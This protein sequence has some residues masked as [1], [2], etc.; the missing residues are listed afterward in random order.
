[1][2]RTIQPCAA[3]GA[4]FRPARE[5]YV[6]FTRHRSD[7]GWLSRQA[8]IAQPMNTAQNGGFLAVPYRKCAKPKKN[9]IPLLALATSATG[10]PTLYLLVAKNAISLRT[11]R[12]GCAR[13][14][15]KAWRWCGIRTFQS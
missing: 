1:M 11:E 3:D 4:F 8:S 10:A 2:W 5:N 15:I 6:F 14:F 7:F 9:C 13:D 12:T